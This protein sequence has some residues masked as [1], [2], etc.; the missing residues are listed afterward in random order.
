MEELP[1]QAKLTLHNA[2]V[3]H[4]DYVHANVL[5][6]FSLKNLRFLTNF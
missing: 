3:Q 1:V 4:T 6:I 2:F 5:P